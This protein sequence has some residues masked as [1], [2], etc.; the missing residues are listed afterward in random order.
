MAQR[1]QRVFVRVSV[2]C[3]DRDESGSHRQ[4]LDHRSYNFQKVKT[5]QTNHIVGSNGK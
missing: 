5:G 4:S 2:K 3:G 1:Q